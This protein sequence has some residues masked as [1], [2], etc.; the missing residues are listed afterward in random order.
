ML[1]PRNFRNDMGSS[2]SERAMPAGS[3]QHVVRL[4]RR[5]WGTKEVIYATK[6]T[7]V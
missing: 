5:F 2:G 1:R 4:L 3:S 7:F 6:S